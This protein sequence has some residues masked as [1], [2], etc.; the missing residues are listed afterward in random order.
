MAMQWNPALEQ[1]QPY[2]VPSSAGLIKLD[3]MENPFGLPPQVAQAFAQRVA[4]LPTNRYPDAAGQALKQALMA[5]FPAPAGYGCVLGNGSDELISLLMM[6]VLRPG[7]CVLAPEPCFV[8]YRHSALALGLDYQAVP[9]APDFSLDME[10]TLAAIE[11]CQPALVFLASPNN[12]TGNLYSADD[13]L[14]LAA[15]SP[16]LFVLDQAYIPYAEQ[17]GAAIA[18]QAPNLVLL[19]TLSKWGLAGLRLGFLQASPAVCEQLEKVRPPYNTNVLSQE[20]GRL[21]LQHAAAFAEQVQV[22]IE[23]RAWLAQALVRPQVEVFDSA[24]N[25]LLLRVP[26]APAWHRQLRDH[27]GIL[28]KCLHG[29]HPHLHNCLRISVGTPAENQALAQAWTELAAR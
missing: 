16:G 19:R 5:E 3:A 22:L 23:Q 14:R 17:D 18:A 10:A 15:A 7:A 2:Q 29:A 27:A 1:M 8:M 13:I 20:L 4:D 28:V 26:D 24:A 21:C 25:F 6:A 9:L 11:R 12:P